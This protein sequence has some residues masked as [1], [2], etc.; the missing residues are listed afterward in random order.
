M[1]VRLWCYIFDFAHVVYIFWRGIE[2]FI[3]L[4]CYSRQFL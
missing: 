4:Y 3:D 1:V 2:T